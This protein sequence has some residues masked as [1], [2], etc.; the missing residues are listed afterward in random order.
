MDTRDAAVEELVMVALVGVASVAGVVVGDVAVGDVAEVDVVVGVVEV[1][2]V[3]KICSLAWGC[4]RR[5]GIESILVTQVTLVERLCKYQA[6][7]FVL[8]SG[9]CEVRRYST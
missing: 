6:D 2:V 5:Y 1:D 7:F 8:Q 3:A 9:S 4:L